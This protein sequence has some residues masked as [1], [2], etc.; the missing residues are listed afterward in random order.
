LCPRGR[1]AA[2]ENE[3]SRAWRRI[4]WARKS[5]L[6]SAKINS[7][8]WQTPHSTL[9]PR[10]APFSSNGKRTHRAALV[11]HMTPASGIYNNTLPFFVFVCAARA[12]HWQATPV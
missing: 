12:R 1:L 10:G 9:L 4:D 8:K 11:S 2:A 7:G 6:R 5:C 3:P